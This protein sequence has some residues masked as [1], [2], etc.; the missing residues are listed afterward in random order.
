MKKIC[1]LT[2]VQSTMSSFMLP[3][4]RALAENGYE[5]TLISN[6]NEEFI[7]ENSDFANCISLPMR[8]GFHILDIFKFTSALKKIFKREKFDAIYYATDNASFYASRAGK[9]AK[10]KTRI[11]AQ[12]GIHYF[13]AS[14]IKRLIMRILEKITCKCSTH[15]R[16][17]SHK[18]MQFAIEEKLCKQEEIKVLGKGGTIGVDLSLYDL[19]KKLDYRRE[20]RESLQ[21]GK[22]DFV[23]GFV[24][25]ITEDKGCRELLKAFQLGNFPA[26]TKLLMVGGNDNCG[27]ELTAFIEESKATE[28]VIFTGAVKGNLVCKYM[29]AMDVLV[30]PTY[31]EGF[32]MVLQEALAMC[33]PIITTD[34]PGPSEV[35]EENVC[36]WLVPAQNVEELKEKMVLLKED[37]LL[38]ERFAKDGR[39]R[40]EQYFERK[41]M[42]GRIVEDFNEIL[43]D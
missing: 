33:V 12:W 30:H 4:A 32:G 26:N 28:K 3:F 40:V 11:Y 21:I 8:R 13:G 31:R 42:V 18:N 37:E 1:F 20:I 23:F 16:S 19:D 15:I 43:K 25:R 17:V 35:I 9:K 38:R 34:I 41:I 39:K 2:T 27:E 6:M 7:Q 22:D 14:G 36:G 5:I 10:I 29:S 24:G